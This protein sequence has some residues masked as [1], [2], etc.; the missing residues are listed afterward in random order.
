[1][2][3]KLQIAKTMLS[4]FNEEAYSSK[5][6]GQLTSQHQLD[7]SIVSRLVDSETKLEKVNLQNTLLRE[8]MSQLED[9]NKDLNSKNQKLSN[10]CRTLQE[11]NKALSAETKQYIEQQE[12]YRKDLSLKFEQSISDVEQKI[13][14]ESQQRKALEDERANMKEKLAEI[15]KNFED[16]DAQRQNEIERKTLEKQLAEAKLAQETNSKKEAFNIINQLQEKIKLLD[17]ALK[18]RTEQVQEYGA[19]YQELI[20]MVT[21]SHDTVKSVTSESKRVQEDNVKLQTK[22]KSLNDRLTLTGVELANTMEKLKKEKADKDK[23][24]KLCRALQERQSY[25]VDDCD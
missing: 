20:D 6:R 25:E 5:L 15:V 16:R 2:T 14:L 24:A 18:E 21:Q 17:Q 19:K 9:E 22:V 4:L 13:T 7:E 11:K 12:T 10:L 23:L 3:D 8:Q 1:M